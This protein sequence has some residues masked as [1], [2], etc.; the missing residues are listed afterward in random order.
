M[1]DPLLL[2]DEGV[3]DGVIREWQKREIEFGGYS[4]SFFSSAS[5]VAPA[6]I[7]DLMQSS[8]EN[9]LMP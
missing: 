4:G 6:A 5:V 7:Y 2:G 1:G 9:G 8:V 3:M